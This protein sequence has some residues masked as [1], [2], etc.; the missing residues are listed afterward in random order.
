MGAKS[1]MMRFLFVLAIR[2]GLR[3]LSDETYIK[4][5]YLCRFGKKI[6][7]K[8]PVTFNEKLQWL[9]IHDRAPIY[10][11]LVDKYAVKKYVSDVIGEKYIIPGYG[12]WDTFDEID[13]ERLPDRFV[14]KCSHDSGGLYICRDKKQMDVKA[15][16]KKINRSLKR[17]Y[18]WAGRE[19]PYKNVPP[20]ILAEKYMEESVDEGLTD[21]KFYCFNGIPRFLYISKGLEDHKTAQIS[22]LSMDWKMER[23][24]RD[25]FRP[26]ERVPERP[27][28]FEEM[29]K[30]ARRLSKGIPFVRVDLYF[31]NG[32]IYFSEL[33]FSPCSGFMRFIPEE[34]DREIGGYIQL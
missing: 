15:V 20:R 8:D 16:R 2:G 7:L 24:R 4:L 27:S 3:S 29:E 33:T 11:T 26:F 13:L 21:Y 17:N 9:K 23:F 1:Q 25:D 10:T 34:A 12:V 6:D 22:F 28:G 31:I 14:L 19:W 5:M 32:H 30:I 18:Y